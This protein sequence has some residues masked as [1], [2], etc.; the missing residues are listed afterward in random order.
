ME[1]LK[2]RYLNTK[3]LLGQGRSP[4]PASLLQELPCLAAQQREV[5]R[6]AREEGRGMSSTGAFGPEEQTPEA[7]LGVPVGSV[8]FQ[9][10]RLKRISSALP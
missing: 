7:V 6:V 3:F 4:F 9:I 8:E 5:E 10:M 1:D 2:D